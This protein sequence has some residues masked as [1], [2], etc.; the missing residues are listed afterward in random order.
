MESFIK[1]QS[2]AVLQTATTSPF[3]REV[4]MVV[5]GLRARVMASDA[6]CEFAELFRLTA[7]KMPLL[8]RSFWHHWEV[9]ADD[10]QALM[11]YSDRG[12]PTLRIE[13]ADCG[14]RILGIDGRRPRVYASGAPSIEAAL[15]TS[16]LH[17]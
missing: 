16:G 15:R 11:V 4:Q 3:G 1:G 14:Y 2:V 7:S 12:V 6:A 10:P 17:P 9:A 13:R 8:Y 5:E